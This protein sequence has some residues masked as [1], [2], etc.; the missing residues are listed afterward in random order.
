MAALFGKIVK[1]QIEC[2][3]KDEDEFNFKAF[4][5]VFKVHGFSKT[6]CKCNQGPLTT[7]FIILLFAAIFFSLE[8]NEKI[9]WKTTKHIYNHMLLW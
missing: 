3:D 5:I 8:Y 2:T 1:V 6:S 7:M 4:C 9:R